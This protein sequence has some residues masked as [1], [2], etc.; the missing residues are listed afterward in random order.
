MQ[1]PSGGVLPGVELT[2]TDTQFGVRFSRVSDGTGWFAF[3]DLQPGRYELNA[4]LPGFATVTNVMTVTAGTNVQRTIT[5]PLGSLEE[6]IYVV[7]SGGP[8]AMAGVPLVPAQRQAGRG[9]FEFA[10][11]GRRGS[12]GPIRVGGQIK[13]P[14]QIGRVNPVCP[15]GIL[16]DGDTVINLIGRIGVDGYM[17]EVRHVPADNQPA[18]PAEFIESALEAVRQWR[19]T[20]TLLNNQPWDVNV[21]VTVLYR[22]DT[23]RA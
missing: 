1:D 19:Y 18:P 3:P 16:P 23:R 4:K 8:L 7:C 9:S 10:P 5:L 21:R 13:A 22:R 15:R 12:T 11:Q 14:N 2:L 17:N 6:T 20:T